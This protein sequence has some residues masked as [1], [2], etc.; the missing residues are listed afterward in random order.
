MI[1]FVPLELAVLTAIFDETPEFVERLRRQFSKAVVLERLNT[2]LG[3]LT[4]ISVPDDLDAIQGPHALGYATY[5]QIDGLK[6]G[7]GFALLMKKGLLYQLDS[8]SLS[9]EN[10]YGLD[11]SEVKFRLTETPPGN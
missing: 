9:G 3:F 4:T 6:H 7:F 8:Y 11:I 2:G 5:A 1:G 10:T